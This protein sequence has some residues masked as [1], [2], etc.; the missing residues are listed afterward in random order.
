ME[1][2]LAVLSFIGGIIAAAGTLAAAALSN[3]EKL[4]DLLD[5]PPVVA[6][7]RDKSLTAKS[8]NGQPD[9]RY[10]CIRSQG[11][12]FVAGSAK[13]IM[14]RQHGPKC[15]YELAPSTESEVCFRVV[16]QPLAKE[17]PVECVGY[18]QVTYSTP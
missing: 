13:V 14:T 9:K 2:V 12:K 11:R 10:D 17:I 18:V 3:L 5:K 8:N 15:E 1:I 6:E 4:R 7:F 16:A